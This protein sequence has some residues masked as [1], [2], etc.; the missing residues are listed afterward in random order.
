MASLFSF[1]RS[2]L[3]KGTLHGNLIWC[4]LP[5]LL[6]SISHFLISTIPVTTMWFV[7]VVYH[8]CIYLLYCYIHTHTHTHP[9]LDESWKPLN[10]WIWFLIDS[11]SIMVLGAW[12]L[13]PYIYRHMC[14]CIYILAWRIP[15]ERGTWKATV[16]GVTKSQTWLKRQHAHMYIWI[17]MNKW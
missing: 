13:P 3:L 12:T 9:F 6:S 5:Q 8:N 10:S 16:H 14:V 7:L 11:A 1:F 17:Y 15:M 4:D 2:H